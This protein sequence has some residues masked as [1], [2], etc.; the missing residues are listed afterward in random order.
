MRTLW[1]L[2][3]ALVVLHMLALAG[4][5]VWLRVDGRLNQDRAQHVINMFSKTIEQDQK[6]LAAGQQESMQRVARQAHEK[7][8]KPVGEGSKAMAD[9]LAA[10]EQTLEL[11]RHQREQQK[12]IIEK[13]QRQVQLARQEQMRQQTKLD[14]E[15]AEFE[16][17]VRV[18]EAKRLDED[19]K[20]AIALLE[21]QKPA[22]VKAMLLILLQDGA[23]DRVVDYLARMQHHKAAKVI[24]EFKEDAEIDIAMRLV[25]RLRARAAVPSATPMPPGTSGD[26]GAATPTRAGDV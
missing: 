17:K 15:R 21:S 5:V 8:M 7:R 2:F 22:Q 14:Q 16:E 23:V 4:L 3:V 1:S 13:L 10:H 18:D 19:L 11:L 26:G 24:G 20:K 9:R 12:R 6:E 25:E